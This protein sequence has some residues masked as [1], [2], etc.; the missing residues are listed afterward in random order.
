MTIG[1]I[2][3]IWVLAVLYAF[4]QSGLK[5]LGHCKASTVQCLL[6][7]LPACNG[8]ATGDAA[9]TDAGGVGQKTVEYARK[10]VGIAGGYVTGGPTNGSCTTPN[11][12]DCSGLSRCAVLNASGGKINLV[13]HAATQFAQLAKYSV[14]VNDQA[15]WKAGDLIFY[16]VAGDVA[17][18]GHVAI[19]IG[20]GK[21]IE[22]AKPGVGVIESD[23][24]QGPG[25]KILGVRR[26]SGA[27]PST[28]GSKNKATTASSGA[29]TMTEPGLLRVA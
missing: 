3:L 24:A 14:P 26:P 6:G 18:P 25:T 16:F 12:F 21:V 13:H 5:L 10:Q 11:N 1:V 22:A 8:T 19:Y 2:P 23:V 27:Y 15:Q 29:S 7:N 28:G 17:S 20:G 9:A 4:T